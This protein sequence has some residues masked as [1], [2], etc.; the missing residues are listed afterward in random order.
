MRERG[1]PLLVALCQVSSRLPIGTGNHP[2]F[3]YV[4]KAVEKLHAGHTV[5]DSGCGHTGFGRVVARGGANGTVAAKKG[6][7][8]GRLELLHGHGK[9]GITSWWKAAYSD[10]PGKTWE[11]EKSLFSDTPALFNLKAP[12]PSHP[13]QHHPI[14][15]HPIPP[16]PIPSHFTPDSPSVTLS[17]LPLYWKTTRP[18]GRWSMSQWGRWDSVRLQH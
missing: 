17:C 6:A 2:I 11:K 14:P 8:K 7:A 4:L 18:S 10:T 3:Y 12:I 16:H 13:T 5:D 1:D 15:P 9:E